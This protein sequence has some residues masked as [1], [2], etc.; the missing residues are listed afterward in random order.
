V[1]IAQRHRRPLVALLSNWPAEPSWSDWPEKTAP[2]VQFAPTDFPAHSFVDWP[3]P[4]ALPLWPV[5]RSWPPR[6]LLTRSWPHPEP[7]CPC[8]S[9]PASRSPNPPCPAETPRFA[10]LPLVSFRPHSASR[11]RPV[12]IAGIRILPL[13]PKRSRPWP[14]SPSPASALLHPPAG[15]PDGPRSAPADRG[16]SRD[17]NAAHPQ[18]CSSREMMGP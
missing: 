11:S 5:C 1:A 17:W 15:S 3:A 8:C 18:V 10:W 9:Q 4:R 12:S 6:V 13:K 16:R 7:P 2:E 14:V